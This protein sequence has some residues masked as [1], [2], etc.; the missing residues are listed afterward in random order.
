MLRLRRASVLLVGI[1]MYIRL[2]SRSKSRSQRPDLRGFRDIKEQMASGSR[3]WPF[4]VKWHHWSFWSP[5]VRGDQFAAAFVWNSLPPHL[6]SPSISRNLFS[7]GLK[8]HLFK[9]A[10]IDK[11]WELRLRVN[12]TELNWLLTNDDSNCTMWYLMCSVNAYWLSWTVFEILRVKFIWVVT[13]TFQ[14]H[15]TSSITTWPFDSQYTISYR[16]CIGTDTISNGPRDIQDQVRWGQDLTFWGHV[17]SLV[18]WPFDS[19]CAGF[20]D[21][22]TFMA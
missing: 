19:H 1:W 10:Y 3:I 15:A 11:L 18:T 12:W 6:C 5:A 21:L 17:M 20:D 16:C 7:A 2:K 13:L 14:V 9:E 22:S 4:K 8:T